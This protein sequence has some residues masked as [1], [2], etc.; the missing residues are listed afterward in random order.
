MAAMAQARYP[1]IE[2]QGIA[3]GTMASLS[4]QA[5]AS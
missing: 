1:N 3:F 4:P 5:S 2:P